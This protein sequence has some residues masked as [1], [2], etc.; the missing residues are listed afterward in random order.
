MRVVNIHISNANDNVFN[1]QSQN[2]DL[3]YERVQ[4]TKKNRENLQTCSKWSEIYSG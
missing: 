4:W 3:R 2:Y 1:A